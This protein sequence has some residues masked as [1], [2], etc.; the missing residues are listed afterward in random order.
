MGMLSVYFCFRYARLLWEVI[1][2]LDIATFNLC[3]YLY[4][5]TFGKLFKMIKDS[6]ITF[7]F[8]YAKV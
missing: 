3:V 1:F 2:Y 6:Y 5:F 8:S 7:A 4:P